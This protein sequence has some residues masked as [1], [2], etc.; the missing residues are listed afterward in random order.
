MF[1]SLV[2]SYNDNRLVGSNAS[3]AVSNFDRQAP[4]YRALAGMAAIRAAD[5]A[6]R[7]G[8]QSVLAYAESPGLFAIAR[9]R[10]DGS[11]RQTLIVFNSSANA[12]RGNIRIDPRLGRFES[13]HGACAPR[14]A[15]PGSYAVALPPLD[16][17]VCR[18]MPSGE[19]G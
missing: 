6:I 4:I 3:T 5:P 19:E 8:E 10:P 16:Y 2:A 18:A 14:A 15:A 7:R 1:P 13:V 17:I 11:G 9:Q 12:V